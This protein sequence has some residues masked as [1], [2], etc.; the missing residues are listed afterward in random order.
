MDFWTSLEQIA[1]RHDVLRHPFYQRWSAGELTLSE[2]ADYAGQYRHAVVALAAASAGAAD[3]A[4][5]ELADQLAA[6]GVEEAAHVELWD[7][8]IDAVGGDPAADANPETARCA[9]TWAGDGQR[10]LLGTLVALYAI[11]SAQPAI[12]RTKREGLAEH[13]GIEGAG[14]A[15]F[16]LHEQLDVEHAAAAASLIVERLPGADP[17]P[18]LAEAERVLTANWQL[19]D[20][21][22]SRVAA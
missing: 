10:D 3:H 1:Q 17:E 4:D 16:A 9:A 2:L 11:E 18:L 20:G 5:G 8:F 13:Y 6:H 21:L 15:Y 14:A 7:Q 19:L 22:G 12:A